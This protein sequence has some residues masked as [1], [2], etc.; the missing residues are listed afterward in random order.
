MVERRKVSLEIAG[1]TVTIFTDSSEDHLKQISL[2]L[3]ETFDEITEQTK[4]P[5]THKTAILAAM[6][7][8]DLY[9]AQKTSNE[10]LKRDAK[11]LGEMTLSVLNDV[12]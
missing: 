10:A 5:M 7:I 9:L 3:N 12:L 11:H 2:L 4:T 1:Q 6:K 8:A